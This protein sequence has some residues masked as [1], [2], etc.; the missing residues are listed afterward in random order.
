VSINDNVM[1]GVSE[2]SF[3]ITEDETL[4][5][6]GVLSLENRGGFTSIRRQPANLG[7]DGYD[8]IVIRVK[9]DG[10]TYY[11]N[12]RTSSGRTVG[13][14]RAPFATQEGTWQ[15]LRVP[16]QNFEYS[17][18]GRPVPTADPL[19]GSDIL[20]VGF[21]LADKQAGPFR[22]EV[23]WIQG[24]RPADAVVAATQTIHLAG[25]RTDIVDTAQAAGSFNTL[26]AAVQ[27][28]DLV[29]VLKGPGPLTV[30]APTDEAFDRLPEG[31]LEF[32]LKPENKQELVDILLYHVV[33]QRLDAAGVIE[34][35]MADTALGCTVLFTTSGDDVLVDEAKVLQADIEATNGIIHVIDT[36]ILPKDLVDRAAST[37]Q[38]NTLLTAAQAA[39]LAG[40]LKDPD[41]NLTVF[42]PTDQAFATLPSQTLDELLLPANRDALAAVLKYHVLPKRVLLS[43]RDEATLADD[44]VEIR[45]DGPSRVNEARI[46]VA[47]I[48]TTNG[49][50]HV[51]D[52]VL[53]PE[54]PQPTAQRQAMH[55][56]DV[57]INRGAPLFNAGELEACA[58]IYELTAEAL[59]SGY[60]DALDNDSRE[61]LRTALEEVHRHHDPR[62]NAW[63][64]RYAL[65][66]VYDQLHGGE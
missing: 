37:G 41:A 27:A 7:L 40:A 61:R 62:S 32:L 30:F 18:F 56:I 51:I 13:S 21:T 20:S 50:I 3:R 35:G 1:G 9:G 29:E 19:A 53:L 2:G 28:A 38:F 64:L 4:V 46:L 45:S 25:A 11:L 63:T 16:L 31:T 39:G 22:L 52:R 34:A 65:D 12:L 59:L 26:V 60:A 10:R 23:A 36:V 17:A 44:P 57:A 66:D 15:E 33:P 49:V 14:Y 55:L 8:S 54:L 24:E 5:F 48:K 58:A 43:I 42:A 47:D 6:S